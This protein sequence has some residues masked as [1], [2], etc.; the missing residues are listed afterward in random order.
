MG[1]IDAPNMGAPAP[2]RKPGDFRRRGVDGPPI[3]PSLDKTRQPKGNKPELIAKA[4][5][6]GIDPAGMTVVQL[7]E[8]LGPEPADAVYAR[9]SSLGDVLDKGGGLE[10]WKQRKHTEGMLRLFADGPVDAGNAAD[11]LAAG[12]AN[13]STFDPIT[14]DALEAAEHMAAAH[15][16]TYVHAVCEAVVR[17][18]PLPPLEDGE[19]LGIPGPLTKRI[20]EQWE[21]FRDRLGLR[22]IGVEL[23]VINDT[24]R[25]AGS[26][27]Y[28]DMWPDGTA[29]VG[30]V[31]TGGL[32]ATYLVQLAAYAAARRYDVDTEQRGDPLDCSQSGAVI[33]W[34]PL[35]D[36][37]DGE[38][39]DWS[40][41]VVDLEHGG[42][43]AEIVAAATEWAADVPDWGTIPAEWTTPVMVVD[44]PDPAP[45]QGIERPATTETDEAT[46]DDERAELRDL[47]ANIG[48]EYARGGRAHEFAAATAHITA[49]TSLQDIRHALTGLSPAFNPEPTEAVAE[50]KPDF[51]PRLVPLPTPDEGDAADPASVD[52]LRAHYAQLAADAPAEAQWFTDIVG[53]AQRAGRSFHMAD[54]Q[55]VRR[56]EIARGL[57]HLAAGGYG[58][59]DLLR[60]L[61][62]RQLGELAHE[63]RHTAGGLVGALS[64]DQAKRFAMDCTNLDSLNI[65]WADDRYVILDAAA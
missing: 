8:A 53:E 64:A 57:Q 2:T 6:R 23:A 29:R 52:T 32:H 49:D 10:L 9:P 41:V 55:T 13:P 18:A 4:E 44:E 63:P 11:I 47:F 28:L 16:G 56:Y 54:A 38:P 3:V 22:S 15:R 39:V 36:A 21:A 40:A 30:D 51:P 27:D 34:Y 37:I 20:A 48:R 5:A 50:R 12:L 19:A 42:K 43:G 61:L 65:E 17:G 7:R 25:A 26:L 1:S 59:D 14:A 46:E 60:A 58:D 62:D 35:S 45:A 33:Y 31:K 24:L